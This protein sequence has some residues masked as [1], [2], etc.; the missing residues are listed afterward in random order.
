M[1]GELGSRSAGRGFESRLF[2]LLRRIGVKAWNLV[3][4]LNVIWL[5]S[6]CFERFLFVCRGLYL[7]S[8][9]NVT[10]YFDPKTKR[11]V[12]FW[13]TRNLIFLLDLGIDITFFNPLPLCHA[14]NSW[15]VCKYLKMRDVI[16][17]RPLMVLSMK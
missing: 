12:T 14:Q 8:K 11:D 5:L 7:R 9:Q 4:L 16:Y 15:G 13:P 10:S 2:Q 1:V 17:R 6:A 3:R